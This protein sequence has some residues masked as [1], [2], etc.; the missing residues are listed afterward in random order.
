MPRERMNEQG[1]GP[2]LPSWVQNYGVVLLE[3]E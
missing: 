1:A 2:R 3:G